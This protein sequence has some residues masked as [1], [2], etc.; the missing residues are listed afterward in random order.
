MAG[1]YGR[2]FRA[3]SFLNKKKKVLTPDSEPSGEHFSACSVR[4]AAPLALSWRR[5]SKDEG[6]QT[7][8]AILPKFGSTKV[9]TGATEF[10]GI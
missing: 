7:E 8:K 10:C 5:P 3:K 6:W 4:F 1:L 9:V 2:K